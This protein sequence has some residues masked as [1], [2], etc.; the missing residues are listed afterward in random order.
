MRRK[1]VAGILP[2]MLLFVSFF[3][4]VVR[5]NSPVAGKPGPGD[6]APPFAVA[7]LDGKIVSL[8]EILKS[9]KAV[10]LNFWGL[11]CG[12]CIEEI[13]YLNPISDRYAGK[14]VVFL[15][16]N[17]DGIKS[18]VIRNMMPKMPNS[19]KYT[20]LPDPEFIIPDLY[21]MSAAPLSIVIGKD[22][23]ITFRH[24]DFQ[25]G[26]EKAIEEALRKVTAGG[27]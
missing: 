3:P 8:G 1:N 27:K 11:R 25:E 17:V 12:S 18:D 20:V 5:A 13:G 26:D 4:S 6:A 22:G 9:G 15:G 21:N 7:D 23:K 14:D 19:P 10:F 24:E 2:V 16:V